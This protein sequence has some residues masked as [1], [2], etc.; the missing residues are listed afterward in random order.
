M[1]T[2]LRMFYGDGH[3]SFSRILEQYFEMVFAFGADGI[4][5][6]EFPHSAYSYTYSSSTWDN[7]TVFL[8][9]DTLAVSAVASSLVLLTNDHEI[10]LAKIVAKHGG[11]M[12]TNGAP[13][14]KSWIDYSVDSPLPPI[15]ENENSN[16]VSAASDAATA[17]LAVRVHCVCV[18][19]HDKK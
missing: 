17:S 1:K 9:P 14:T 3:N 18:V 5:H 10:E 13:M 12:V 6:D 7:R 8:D 4:F 2:Q 16:S 19:P 15:G 11:H